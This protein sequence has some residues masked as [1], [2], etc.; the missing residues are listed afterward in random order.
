VVT[1]REPDGRATVRDVRTGTT[2]GVNS[3]AQAGELIATWLRQAHAERETDE[4]R[5]D[6][7]SDGT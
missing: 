2:A 7:V 4:A 1:V 6:R 5:E 3:P